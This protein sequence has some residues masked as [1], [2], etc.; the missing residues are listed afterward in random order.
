MRSMKKKIMLGVRAKRLLL[1][2]LPLVLLQVV[3]LTIFVLSQSS[4]ELAGSGVLIAA[5]LDGIGKSLILSVFASLIFDLLEKRDERRT[6][7]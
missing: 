7:H 2:T 3:A 1:W 4:Y 6:D 5:M